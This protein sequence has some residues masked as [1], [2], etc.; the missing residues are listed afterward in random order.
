MLISHYK[1]ANVPQSLPFTPNAMPYLAY[2][3]PQTPRYI[4]LQN[5]Y[6]LTAFPAA[7]N[8]LSLLAIRRR[9]QTQISIHVQRVYLKEPY[10]L[11]DVLNSLCPW[12]P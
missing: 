11:A 3:E 12:G 4:Q 10:S 6:Q 9:I 5:S 7:A 1:A 8:I 2:M